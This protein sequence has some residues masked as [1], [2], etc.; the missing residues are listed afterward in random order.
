VLRALASIPRAWLHPVD[1]HIF[2]QSD[3]SNRAL[4]DHLREHCG[5]LAG[6]GPRFGNSPTAASRRRWRIVSGDLRVALLAEPCEEFEGYEV[7][8]V[9]I[10]GS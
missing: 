6:R 2:D 10:P 1:S 4:F 5:A 7:I 8:E 3:R 9:R